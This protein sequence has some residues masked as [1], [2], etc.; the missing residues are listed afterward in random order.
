MG[1]GSSNLS[2][3]AKKGRA[4]D[5][6][7]PFPLWGRRIAGPF[8]LRGREI[9]GPSRLPLAAAPSGARGAG[10]VACAHGAA[11]LRLQVLCGLQV[12]AQLR[13]GALRYQ[14]IQR[15]EP[16]EGGDLPQVG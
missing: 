8:L 13:Q 10:F 5:L 16:G 1:V 14:R 12:R 3:R 11:E 9:A 6:A 4:G 15:G 7:G 2:G